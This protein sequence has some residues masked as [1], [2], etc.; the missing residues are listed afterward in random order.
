MSWSFS[1]IG[2]PG[3]LAAKA[4]VDMTKCRCIEPEQTIKAMAL[5]IIEHSLL[6]MP[7]DYPVKIIANGSQGSPVE[8][9]FVNNFTL[10]IEPIYGFVKE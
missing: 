8:G 7:A 9:Q 6:A 4:R 5:N 10:T 3:P 2:L 1:G